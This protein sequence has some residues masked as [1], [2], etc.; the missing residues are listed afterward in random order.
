MTQLESQVDSTSESIYPIPFEK[1]SFNVA[2]AAHILGVCQSTLFEA[3]RLN[4]IRSFKVGRARR[5]TGAAI[6]AFR[7]EGC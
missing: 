3:L 4:Q 6:D 2:Q 1:R 7:S 5:I